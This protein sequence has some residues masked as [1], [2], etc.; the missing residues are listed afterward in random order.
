M[1][2]ESDD[3][4]FVYLAFY[5][6]DRKDG[7][8]ALAELMR[9]YE[10]VVARR[11]NGLCRRYP[12]PRLT[13]DEL[14]SLTFLRAVERA[15]KYEAIGNPEATE[16]ETRRY[17]AAWLFTIARNILWSHGRNPAAPL[18]YESID[19]EPDALSATDVAVLAV[20]A[21]PDKFSSNDI[22]HI[23]EAFDSLSDQAQTVMIWTLD[24]RKLSPKGTHMWRGSATDLAH[25]LDTT[26]ENVRKIRERALKKMVAAVTSRTSRGRRQ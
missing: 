21:Y 22:E 16:D 25:R 18:P 20:D 10:A 15:E 4:L 12:S 1:E 14:T 9:R 26:A 23:A 7:D 6:S 11:C 2:E 19:P 17:T 8:R 3:G 13:G 5:Q 24:R